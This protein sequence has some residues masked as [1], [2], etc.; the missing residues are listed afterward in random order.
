MSYTYDFAVIAPGI[1]ERI[2]FVRFV[3]IEPESR[4][5]SKEMGTDE[6]CKTFTMSVTLDFV[7]HAIHYPREI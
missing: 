6:C 2:L 4:T 3:A 1:R 5:L 7:S